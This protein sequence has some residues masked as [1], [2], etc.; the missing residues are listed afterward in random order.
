MTYAEL[1][2][3]ILKG[4]AL[5]GTVVAFV[6]GLVQYSGAQRWKRS[7]WVAQEMRQFF[8]DEVVRRALLMIDWGER[9]IT[10]PAETAEASPQR[11][12][13]T[14]AMVAGALKHHSDRPEGFKPHE[15]AIRDTFD[16]F[17]D[18]LER[19]AS[20]RAAKLVTADDIRPYLAYWIHHV[21][22]AQGAADEAHRLVQL[23]SYIEQYG[24][25][26]VQRLF[27]DY[28]NDPLLSVP[29]TD[30]WRYRPKAG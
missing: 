13:V 30:W 19:F 16:R 1:A 11:V 4:L 17:L 24:F 12:R 10:F 27:E 20:F 7:E 28:M 22:S 29:N 9:D 18:G 8:G 5:V 21:R 14:D 15:T 23:R 3:V 25:R 26:G 6:A 2:D